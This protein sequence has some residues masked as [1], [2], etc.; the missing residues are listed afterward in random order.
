MIL[1]I[2]YTRVYMLLLL[3]LL[4]CIH[5]M[6]SAILSGLPTDGATRS[7]PTDRSSSP[8]Y[9]ADLSLHRGV[10]YNIIIHTY[11]YV[12][13]GTHARTAAWIIINIYYTGTRY[14]PIIYY[15][16]WKLI[17]NAANRLRWVYYNITRHATRTNT[18]FVIQ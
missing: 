2:L 11:T 1:C 12:Y 15:V 18:F 14:I 5:Y 3:L 7:P 9:A 13:D 16:P 10:V 8:L 4:L 17:I 6:T